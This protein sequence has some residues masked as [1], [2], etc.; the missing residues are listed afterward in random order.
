[1]KNNLK[2]L[3]I[4][5]ILIVF[6][7]CV[8]ILS[9]KFYRVGLAEIGT[10]VSRAE[11]VMERD[12]L[13]VLH[14]KNLDLKLPMASTT[15]ILTAITVIENCNLNKTVTVPKEAVGIEGSSMYLKAGESISV[16]AL[17]YGLM[18]RSGNDS[19]IALAL[20]TSPTVEDF[21]AL[22]NA[23]AI[24]IGANNSSFKNPH[25]LSCEG[26]F[27]TARDLALIT[28]YALKNPTFSKI[29]GTKR[30]TFGNRTFINKN[31]MLA[32]YDGSNGVKTGYTKEAGRC[33]VSSAT[34]NDMQ[35]VTVVL[36]CGPMFERS[37]EL[38]DFAFDKYTL[39]TV[40]KK[41]DT[42]ATLPV[43]GFLKRVYDYPMSL[44]KDIVLPLTEDE[45]LSL[46]YRVDVVNGLDL[47]L[48]IGQEVGNLSITANNNLIF[49]S[50]LYNIIGVKSSQTRKGIILRLASDENQ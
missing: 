19:A 40:I 24:N 6:M 5:L 17:L 49:V 34:K 28:C 27:T 15:K 43:K 44:E 23:T 7:S 42:I 3:I 47:P 20:A 12:S 50:K 41:G 22:M 25:G 18:L 39:K 1:M 2:S 35:L 31:K 4:R 36:N 8:I 13:R 33:L 37:K 48:K 16:E 29:V 9:P 11:C 38:L 14:G 30:I 46:N 10:D 26:H 21:V 32:S 45:F